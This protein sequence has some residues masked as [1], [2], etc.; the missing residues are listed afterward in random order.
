MM[1]L[2]YEVKPEIC[3]EVG[4]FAGSSIYP[5]ASALKFLHCGVVYAIDSWNNL[6]CIKGYDSDD[7]N[8]HWKWINLHSLINSFLKSP[9]DEIVRSLLIETLKKPNP[10]K[11]ELNQ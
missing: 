11:L 5:T 10:I 2:I 9:Y 7:A 6:D 3:V 8:Y 1:D 4:V